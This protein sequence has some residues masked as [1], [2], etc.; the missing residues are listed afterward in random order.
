MKHI[1]IS[2]FLLLTFQFASYAQNEQK[3]YY[4]NLFKEKIKSG[5]TLKT[6]G[7][8]LSVTGI[9]VVG[10]F[11]IAMDN[12][13]N[14]NRGSYYTIPAIGGIGL[15]ICGGTFFQIGKSRLKKYEVKLKGISLKMIPDTRQAISLTWHF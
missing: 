14:Q 7:I 9:V 11:L 15:F 12:D 3:L 6:T 2:F 10:T 5:K 1:C 13:E 8:I 4:Q